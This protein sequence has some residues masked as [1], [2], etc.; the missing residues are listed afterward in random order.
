MV[1][2]LCD[3]GVKEGVLW[4]NVPI[5]T[6]SFSTTFK[7]QWQGRVFAAKR[8]QLASPVLRKRAEALLERKLFWLAQRI[9]H[10]HIVE[11]AGIVLRDPVQ[12]MSVCILMEFASRGTLRGHL[13]VRPRTVLEHSDIQL[14]FAKHVASAMSYLHSLS[15]PSVQH[16]NLRTSNVLLFGIGDEMQTYQCKVADAGLQPLKNLLDAKDDR[17]EIYMPPEGFEGRASKESDVYAYAM[18]L[19]ELLTAQRP[20]GDSGLSM[21]EVRSQICYAKRPALSEQLLRTGLGELTQRCWS[22]EPSKRPTFRELTE[23][24]GAQAPVMLP[25]VVGGSAASAGADLG[26]GAEMAAA[27]AA[28]EAMT[29]ASDDGAGLRLVPNARTPSEEQGTPT[30]QRVGRARMSNF[31]KRRARANAASASPSPVLANA[32]AAGEQSSSEP[33]T[34]VTPACGGPLVTHGGPLVTHGGP[35][36]VTPASPFSDE[37]ILPAPVTS[38][39]S[40]GVFDAIEEVETPTDE[41]PMEEAEAPAA[42]AESHRNGSGARRQW[43]LR[44][45]SVP[46]RQSVDVPRQPADAPANLQAPRIRSPRL[47]RARRKTFLATFDESDDVLGFGLSTGNDPLFQAIVSSV[48]EGSRA[49]EQNVHVG[50]VVMK[51]NDDSVDGLTKNQVVE[52]MT[53]AGRPLR[54]LL[55]RTSAPQSSRAKSERPRSSAAKVQAA[56]QMIAPRVVRLLKLPIAVLVLAMELSD[57]LVSRL[58]LFVIRCVAH[59]FFYVGFFALYAAYVGVFVEQSGRPSKMLRTAS[60]KIAY[61]AQI[62]ELCSLCQKPTICV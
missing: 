61:A 45:L 10:P 30:E 42:E 56:W 20:W 24:L 37:G 17:M 13:D 8:M 41:A 29:T 31:S 62:G 39:P 50:D 52:Q 49:S 40:S 55:R 27:P 19:Y 25:S 58:Y 57:R 21:E 32:A 36:P 38:T 33:T 48:A 46:A 47:G 3:A 12:P 53:N 54:L 35:L 51:V 16:D 7:V 4:D 28:V 60:D 14:R 2:S 5:G 44:Q 6:G 23:E 15:K 59:P 9:K 43:S 34:P 18:I 1:A 22:Q 26:A 11:L